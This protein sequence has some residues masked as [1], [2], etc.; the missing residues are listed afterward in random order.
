MAC[1]PPQIGKPETVVNIV[2]TIRVEQCSLT[3]IIVT[4]AVEFGCG[5]FTEILG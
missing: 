2:L 5:E 1:L 4:I 3:F